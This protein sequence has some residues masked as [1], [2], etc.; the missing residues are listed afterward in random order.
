MAPRPPGYDQYIQGQEREQTI[1][2]ALAERDPRIVNAD[3]NIAQRT[4]EAQRPSIERIGDEAYTREAGVQRAEAEFE[5][6]GDAGKPS[7]K[8]SIAALVSSGGA[9]VAG[10]TLDVEQRAFGGE[11]FGVTDQLYPGSE[12]VREYERVQNVYFDMIRTLSGAAISKEEQ[13][14]Q[15]DR[16]FAKRLDPP[17]VVENKQFDRTQHLIDQINFA[18]PAADQ[19][20]VSVDAVILATGERDAW[21]ALTDEQIERYIQLKRQEANASQEASVPPALLDPNLRNR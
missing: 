12:T 8:Q 15:A 9:R 18:G 7:E 4:S 1:Q 2:D 16:F 19:V 20:G 6:P 11:G 10:N 14:L 17:S 21:H 13:Q 5:G 3:V